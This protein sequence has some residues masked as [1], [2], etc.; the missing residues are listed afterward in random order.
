MGSKVRYLCDNMAVVCAVNKGAGKSPHLIQ[1]LQILAFCCAMFN[2]FLVAQHLL[3]ALNT[4]ADALSRNNYTLS[5]ALNPQAVPAC[6]Q[7]LV[8][9]HPSGG[10]QVG[11]SS[12]SRTH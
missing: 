11:G 8:L 10:P 1:R 6:L 4:S 12:S 9:N 2:I 7:E 5:S 3:G